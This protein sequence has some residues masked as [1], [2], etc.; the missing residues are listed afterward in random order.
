MFEGKQLHDAVDRAERKAQALRPRLGA[1]DRILT[2]IGSEIGGI[3]LIALALA[4][5]CAPVGM[6]LA[7]VWG[8]YAGTVALTGSV[9][10]GWVA[11]VA[12]FALLCRYVWGTRLQ[13][14][15]KRGAAALVASR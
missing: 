1:A 2:A 11:G 8:A 6:G 10:L 9:F 7:V 12:V 14:A 3:L 13:S 5:L 15:A 4:I